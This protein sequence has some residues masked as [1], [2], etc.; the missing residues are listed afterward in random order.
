LRQINVVAAA[1][2]RVCLAF[3]DFDYDPQS[4]TR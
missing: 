1:C 3:G 2:V 4:W